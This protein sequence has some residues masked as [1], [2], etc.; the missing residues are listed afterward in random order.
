MLSVNKNKTIGRKIRLHLQF[1]NRKDIGK[2][3]FKN[4]NISDYVKVKTFGKGKNPINQWKNFQIWENS[5]TDDDY[6]LIS[7]KYIGT[8][9]K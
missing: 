6:K 8:I 4:V 5:G 3:Y 7:I 2:L 1:R 9:A